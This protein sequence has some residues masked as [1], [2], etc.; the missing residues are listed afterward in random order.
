MKGTRGGQGG[1]ASRDTHCVRTRVNPKERTFPS[2]SHVLTNQ[3][4][5]ETPSTCLWACPPCTPI[6]LCPSGALAY[7][8]RAK[9]TNPMT[10]F[11]HSI[12]TR[13]LIQA[14]SRGLRPHCSQPETHS[15]WTS[16]HE[17]ERAHAAL[18]CTGCPV[19]VECGEAAEANDER[20]G[21][22]AGVDRS[23][24]PGR[25]RRPKPP[26]NDDLFAA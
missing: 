20:H 3:S 5:D 7:P 18:W 12:L 25:G 6:P 10:P 11:T 16:E 26:G 13:S 9:A 8:S 2:Q 4:D 22:W 24:R 1:H 15:Y 23:V 19:W 21:V 17:G 14:A